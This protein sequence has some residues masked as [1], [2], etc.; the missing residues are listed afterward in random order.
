MSTGRTEGGTPTA[1]GAPSDGRSWR[2]LIRG[3][4][5]WLSLVSLLNDAAS[6]M[7]YPLLPLFVTR[8][9]GAGPAF[10]GLLEGAADSASSILKLIGGRVSDRVRR[11]KPLVA[12]GY[13]IAATVRPLIA[14]ASAGWHVLAVRLADRVGKGI[15]TAPRDALLAES[16]D[17]GR[18][19]VAF[20]IHRGA[21]H[22]GAV[23]GPLF[24]TGFLL[25]FPYALRPLF[26]ISLVP[27][28]IAVAVVLFRVRERTLHAPG[29]PEQPA[30]SSDD[31]GRDV[32]SPGEHAPGFD[33]YLFVLLLFTL[34]NASDAFLL[35]RAQQLGVAV[36]FLPLL[37]G[38]FHVSKMAWSVPGGAMADRIGPRPAILTGWSVYAAVYAGFAF[39]TV[40]WHV[41]TLFLAYGLFYG[42]T[43]SPEKALVARFASS[44]RRGSA[45]GAYHFA[46]GLAALPASLIFGEIYQHLSAEVAFLYGAT[47][48]LLSALLFLLLVP[49]SPDTAA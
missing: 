38:A 10:L 48:A 32:A 27:G 26:A 35:L 13:A 44:A 33:R 40:E 41:W 22:A 24:A 15:R 11:R 34:G 29:A 45:F 12:S 1:G 16:V 39:A 14:L 23:L 8:Y 6:E 2:S 17:A 31:A 18:R 30:A 7:I 36:A 21:D 46:I 20:G 4:V 9:L 47:L 42:L 3:N 49:R 37:W 19:G 5:A 25:L 28:A 43:E